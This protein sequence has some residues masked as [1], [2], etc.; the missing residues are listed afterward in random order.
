MNQ[1]PVHLWSGKF[2]L[3]SSKKFFFFSF[4]FSFSLHCRIV[5]STEHRLTCMIDGHLSVGLLVILV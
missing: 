2:L 1:R 5:C 3:H 4:F